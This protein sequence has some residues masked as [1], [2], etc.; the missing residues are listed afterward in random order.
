MCDCLVPLDEVAEKTK[1]TIIKVRE[2]CQELGLFIADDWA[3]RPAVS[4]N[5]ARALVDGSAR[6]KHEHEQAE[7]EHKVECEQWVVDRSAAVKRGADDAQERETRRALRRARIPGFGGPLSEAEI[8]ATRHEGGKR[9]GEQY[10]R[11]TPRPEFNGSREA[12]AL[13]YV[14]PDEEGSLLAAAVGALRRTAR[15]KAPT[16]MEVE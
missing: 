11:T 2:E 5:D 4:E 9:A 8:V 15:I 16:V 3:G 13:M 14:T 6:R 12:V 7:R 1:K 10:E